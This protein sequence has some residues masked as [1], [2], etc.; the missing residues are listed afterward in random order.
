MPWRCPKFQ[1]LAVVKKDNNTKYSK[2]DNNFIWYPVEMTWSGHLITFFLW[3]Q[4]NFYLNIFT[5]TFPYVCHFVGSSNFKIA[6][7]NLLWFFLIPSKLKKNKIYWLKKTCFLSFDQLKENVSKSYQMLNYI[8]RQFQYLKTRQNDMI[9]TQ[10]L[11]C[12]SYL[13][14]ASNVEIGVECQIIVIVTF[15]ILAEFW[16]LGRL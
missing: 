2:F 6:V 10:N 15:L 7:E 14:R 5:H 11:L 9:H 4:N 8:Q 1:N 13:D 12:Q 16:H 3:V